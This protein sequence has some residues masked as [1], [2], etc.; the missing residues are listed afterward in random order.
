[1]MG[2]LHCLILDGLDLKVL[3][4]LLDVAGLIE[5][6]LDVSVLLVVVGDGGDLLEHLGTGTVNG[7]DRYSVIL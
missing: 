1:M 5:C 2:L 7:L 4:G 3:L 6:S